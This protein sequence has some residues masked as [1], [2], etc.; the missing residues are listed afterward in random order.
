MKLKTPFIDNYRHF[1]GIFEDDADA[2]LIT[3]NLSTEILKDLNSTE[4][5]HVKLQY[6]PHYDEEG[7]AEFEVVEAKFAHDTAY[8]RVKF[9]CT[10]K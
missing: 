10:M 2:D 3:Q 8:I 6:L 4:R 9:I 7:M 5:P 1:R